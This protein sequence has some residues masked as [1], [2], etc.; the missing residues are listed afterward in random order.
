MTNKFLKENKVQI[1]ISLLLFVS[2]FSFGSYLLPRDILVN[3]I[4]SNNKSV[5]EDV[6]GDFSD[7]IELYNPN[8][9]SI[10]LSGY[11]LSDDAENIDKWQFPKVDI[12]PHSYIVLFA[13]SKNKFEHGELHTNFKINQNGEPI[14]LSFNSEIIHHVTP[15]YI[16]SDQ[17]LSRLS[18][19]NDQMIVCDI[20]T[21]NKKNSIPHGVYPS[22]STGFYVKPFKLELLNLNEENQIYYTVNGNSPTVNSIRYDGPLDIDVDPLN[23]YNYSD[24]PTT[25]LE[26]PWPLNSFVWKEPTE[27]LNCKVIR[28][29][30]FKDGVQLG[31]IQSNTYFV[32]P[33][34]HN[35]FHFNVISL[36]T[37]SLNLFDH[38]T[39]IYIPGKRFDEMGF[40]WCPIGNYHNRGKEWEREVF[41]T[42][43]DG[44]GELGFET[45]AGMRM[46]G[47]G[48][49]GMPQKSFNIYFR[50]KYGISS[51]DY[52]I[53]NNPK[54]DRYKR[55]IFRNSGGDFNSTHFR[56]ALLH[57]VMG[58]MNL[59]KQESQPSVVYINGEYWGI[60]NIRE[61]Y[62]KHYLN[63]KLGANEDS[64]NILGICGEIE[65]G[66]NSDYLELIDFVEENTLT[67]NENYLYVSSEIDIDNF[68]DFQIAEIYFA[69]Y[70]WPGNN[71]KIWR[72]QHPKSKWRFLIFDL[73]FSFGLD[74]KSNFSTNSM[75]HATMLGESWPHANCSNLLFRKLLENEEFKSQFLARFEYHLNTTFKPERIN[76]IIDG[77]VE[78]YS[79]EI[80]HQIRRWNYP[81]L[82]SEWENEVDILREFAR[83]RPWYMV[84]NIVSF[85]D[86]SGFNGLPGGYSHPIGF[87]PYEGQYV[88]R[89]SSTD[90]GITDGD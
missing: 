35:R 84:N 87:Q 2:L 27:R 13:S 78:N 79:I 57:E 48:S 63:Y 18:C 44:K 5:L 8:F 72:S 89:R 67:S 82:F 40:K 81:S 83:K 10:D 12:P 26:G 21:P 71:F 88:H 50:N 68:I 77:F 32:D 16:Q 36:V 52:P 34:I 51:V 76:D 55:I 62:D 24:I 74:E 9:F 28:Y 69:N 61:K 45:S 46:R 11:S 43:F 6:D 30:T 64:V 23:P 56:D 53:F 80:V 22:H 60:H 58:V 3:E 85:F 54:V 39:G 65:E 47:Y 73:D 4:A 25:P 7:W 37:D 14:I 29:A 59:E 86:L 20:P 15:V 19:T 17:S 33:E 1:A 90:I 49:T 66:D 75:E 41:L 42:F 31:R 70:D 38:E